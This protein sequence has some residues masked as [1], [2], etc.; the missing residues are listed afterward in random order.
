MLFAAGEWENGTAFNANTFE[1]DRSRPKHPAGRFFSLK[2]CS[3]SPGLITMTST[4]STS[5]TTTPTP[6]IATTIATTVTTAITTITTALTTITTATTTAYAGV[7]ARKAVPY[8]VVVL[9]LFSH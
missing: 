4:A 8:P 1:G 3:S 5:T 2:L 6:T 7:A 9:L